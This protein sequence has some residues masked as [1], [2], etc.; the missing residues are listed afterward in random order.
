MHY[1]DDSVSCLNTCP[2]SS[3]I[4]KTQSKKHIGGRQNKGQGNTT[5]ERIKLILW[6]RG[7]RLKKAIWLHDEVVHISAQ[8][9]IL[10]YLAKPDVAKWLF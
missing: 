2:H 3:P 6:G 5:D 7:E 1:L 4:W 9:K 8:K 10:H